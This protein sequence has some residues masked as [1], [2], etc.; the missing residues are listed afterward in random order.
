MKQI[1]LSRGYGTPEEPYRRVLQ[2]YS[3]NGELLAEK[4]EL[5]QAEHYYLLRHDRGFL[6]VSQHKY[7][8]QADCEAGINGSY[9]VIGMIFGNDMKLYENKHFIE[10]NTK[11]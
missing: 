5:P 2:Y 6:A 10:N 1:C 11:E 4:D 3:L 9:T 7:L 8:S